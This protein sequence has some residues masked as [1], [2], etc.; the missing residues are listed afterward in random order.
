MGHDHMG[1]QWVDTRRLRGVA[2]W[3]SAV[4]WR[5]SGVAWW[6][7]VVAWPGIK[8]GRRE[9]QGGAKGGRTPLTDDVNGIIDG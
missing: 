6:V 7:S 8:R 1:S 9:S 3:V 2:W 5:V 4:A